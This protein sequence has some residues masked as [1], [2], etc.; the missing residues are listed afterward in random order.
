MRNII[1]PVFKLCIYCAIFLLSACRVT[2]QADRVSRTQENAVNQVSKEVKPLHKPPYLEYRAERT[3]LHDLIHT[4]LQVSFDWEKQHLHGIATLDLR[5]YFYPQSE[6]ILDAKGFDIHEISML[7]GDKKVNLNYD[8]LE[9]QLFIKLGR[10]FTRNEQYQV[11]IRYTAK[12]NERETSGSSAISDDKGLYFI[13]PDGSDPSKP[14]QIWTQGETEANSV[15][16]PTIDAPN[17]RCTQEMYITVDKKFKTLSNGL[18][19]YSQLNEDGTRTDYWKM[20]MPHTP[21]LFMMAIGEYAVVEDSWEDIEVN[22]YVEPEYEPYAKAIFG[23]TPEMLSFFSEKLGYKFPWPKYSQVVVRDFVSGA[24]EN[25]TASIFY[26]DVQVDDRELLDEDYEGIIAH[27]LFHQWFGNV[28]TTESWSNLPLNESFANYSEYLWSEYKYGADQADYLGL[29]EMEKYFNE[30]ASKRVDMIRFYYDDKEDMFDS[31]SYAKGGRI[32]HMLRNYV[33]DDAFFSSLQHYLITHEFSDVEIH[34]LRLSFEKVTGEDLNWFFNQWFLA[35]GHPELRVSHVYEDKKLKVRVVQEQ[36]LD[37]TPLYR[38]PLFI[39][40]WVGK[41]KKR[42]PVVVQY[43]QEYFEFPLEK[44]PD[45]VLFDGDQQLLAEVE[46][47]KNLEENLFQFMHAGKFL[48]RYRAAMAITEEGVGNEKVRKAFIKAL[49]DDFWVIRKLAV[50]AFEEYEGP[51][52]DKVVQKLKAMVVEDD[53]SLVRAD[54]LTALS[55]IEPAQHKETI[56]K[57]LNDPSYAVMGAALFA[58]LQLPMIDNHLEVLEKYESYDKG[59]IFVPIANFYA[60]AGFYDKYDWFI[61]KIKKSKSLNLYYMLNFLG[62]ALMDAPEDV[63][64]KGAVVLENYAL[65]S[66]V[67]Y[68][69][70]GGYQGLLLL[71]DHSEI[72]AKRSRVFEQEKDKRLIKIYKRYQE[73]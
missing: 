56:E 14:Q 73:Q 35:S 6:L 45:L 15:W 42:Y 46:H 57:A 44:A 8:Y 41:E 25:T 49:D 68:V 29:E 52:K 40:V 69:R 22:Y 20:D 16:F 33:G 4:K 27:E 63:K 59:S 54:A 70:L 32:L 43:Q 21:Y 23:K 67:Y 30:A 28:V 62:R 47:E 2:D 3:K 5:P 24:M 64:L 38:L 18:L 53:K 55:S 19:I 66:P 10:T 34:D 48:A 71:G 31:H 72:V 26:E 37:T 36:D 17:Q 50:N 1:Q 51:E 7:V 65:Q 61:E 13:N 39:D 11:E 58:Y 60:E 12:P 9:D